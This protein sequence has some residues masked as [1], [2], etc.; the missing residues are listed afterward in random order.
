MSFFK[1]KNKFEDVLHSIT[2]KTKT[3]INQTRTKP[4]ETLE[5]KIQQSSIFFSFDNPKS[6]EE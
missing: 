4:Q 2:R 6:L 5:F 1:T 3:L